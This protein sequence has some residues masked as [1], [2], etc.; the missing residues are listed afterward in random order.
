MFKVDR[1]TITFG[2]PAQSKSKVDAPRKELPKKAKRSK[3]NG[4]LLNGRSDVDKVHHRRQKQEAVKHDKAIRNKAKAN[5]S[6]R[7]KLIKEEKSQKIN[8]QV[9][10]RA[11]RRVSQEEEKKIEIEEEE[12]EV[13]DT[14]GKSL[15]SGRD[16]NEELKLVDYNDLRNYINNYREV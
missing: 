1:G 6:D 15:D 7:A 4:K 3:S 2:R 12:K 11:S 14:R 10:E 5:Q 16:G 13:E 8:A 9:S